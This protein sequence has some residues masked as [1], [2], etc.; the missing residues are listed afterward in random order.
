VP[1]RDEDLGLVDEHG[2]PRGSAGRGAAQLSAIT[3]S[4]CTRLPASKRT[5]PSASA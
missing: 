5:V 3:A 2:R 4:T 1:G